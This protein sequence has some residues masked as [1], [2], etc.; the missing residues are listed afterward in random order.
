MILFKVFYYK[1]SSISH[2]QPFDRKC[3]IY[4]P[5]ERHLLKSKLIP[6][7]E[8]GI[9]LGYTN[10][11]YIYKV[12]ILAH[13]HIFIMSTLEIKFEDTTTQSLSTT[14]DSHL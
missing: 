11:L 9:F 7:A 3:F 14:A 2:L 12:Y 8:E 13:N 10:T 6:I 4:I 5:K 1:K